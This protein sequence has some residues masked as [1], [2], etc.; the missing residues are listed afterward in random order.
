MPNNTRIRKTKKKKTAVITIRAIEDEKRLL[1]E[2]AA[3]N[4]MN[5]SKYMIRSGLKNKLNGSNQVVANIRNAVIVQQI[6]NH[7]T[8]T[9]GK[10]PSLEKWSTELWKS[11]S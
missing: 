9:Y 7:V 3:K 2:N 6:C 4:N 10:D 5:L 8:D 11:L 1:E